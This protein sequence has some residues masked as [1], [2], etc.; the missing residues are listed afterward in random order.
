MATIEL[1]KDNFAETIQ[2]KEIVLVDYWAKW[3]GP[4]RA[5]G[6]IFEKAAEKH[7][8]IVFA[9]CDTE[10]QVELA[11]ALQIHS[12]PTLM[13]FKEG[14]LV[15]SQPGMLPAPVLEELIEKVRELDM[16]EVRKTIAEHEAQHAAEH[17]DAD[18][19]EEE[20][21]AAAN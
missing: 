1:T 10:K 16:D 8:D 11:S 21:A 17:A 15:F 9:K 19:A 14:V 5:F 13:V 6:P 3:C 4:C 12:I 7:P 18:H 2:G 20:A